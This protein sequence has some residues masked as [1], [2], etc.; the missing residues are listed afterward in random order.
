MFSGQAIPVDCDGRVRQQLRRR[1]TA[2]PVA[3][4]D[5]GPP[6]AWK[7]CSGQAFGTNHPGRQQRRRSNGGTR[8]LKTG[9]KDSSHFSL[10]RIDKNSLLNFY[11]FNTFWT[12]TVSFYLCIKSFLCQKFKMSNRN[13][14]FKIFY[15]N[16]YL[17]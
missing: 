3:A 1:W 8:S 5:S 10:F 11:F 13:T 17:I 16:P 2:Q 6:L 4:W 9:P 7:S 15:D 12:K 14:T